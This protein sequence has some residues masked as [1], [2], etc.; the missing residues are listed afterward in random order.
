MP[1][2]SNGR[3]RIKRCAD[4][5]LNMLDEFQALLM[6]GDTR[7]VRIDSEREREC[8]TQEQGKPGEPEEMGQKAAS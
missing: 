5:S 6:A 7:N 8:F 1:I 4:G 2:L 3:G